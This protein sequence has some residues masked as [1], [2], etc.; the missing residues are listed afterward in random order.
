[1][2]DTF[3][4]VGFLET[5]QIEVGTSK[6]KLPMYCIVEAVSIEPKRGAGVLEDGVSQQAEGVRQ[7]A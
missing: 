6:M 2:H 7:P 4:D 1:M 3:F 5:N